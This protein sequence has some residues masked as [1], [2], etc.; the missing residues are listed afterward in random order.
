MSDA[1][2]LHAVGRTLGGD[3]DAFSEIVERYTP[4]VYSLA[5]RMLGSSEEAEE[6][7]QEVFLKAYRSLGRFR[8]SRRCSKK[9]ATAVKT[10]PRW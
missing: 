9:A 6:A 10:S 4:V 2:D 1:A 5:A 7:T 8:L 3:P